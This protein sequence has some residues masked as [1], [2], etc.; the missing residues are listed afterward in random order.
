MF[1]DIIMTT[2]LVNENANSYFQNIYGDSFNGDISFISTLRA[3]VAPRMGDDDVL[4]IKFRSS[5][6]SAGAIAGA[7]TTN[8]IK[9]ICEYFYQND[10]GS[11]YIHNFYH[12]EQDSNVAC[13]ELMKSSFCKVFPGWVRLEKV[14]DFYHKQFLTMCFINPD[15]KSVAIFVDNMDIRKMHYL[16]CS[17]FA[18]L[19]WYFDPKK[20]VNEL[21][22]ELINSL[23]EK[24]SGKY[25]EVISKI[26]L[27]YDFRSSK[28]KRLLAGF[29]TKFERIECNNVRAQID[30]VR[31][32]I[33]SLNRQ[34]GDKLR[35]KSGLEIRLLGLESKISSTSEDSEIMEYFL[36]NSNLE[37]LNVY[38]ETMIFGVKTYI[39]YFDEDMAASAIRN[40]Q[41]YLYTP[42][43][44]TSRRIPEESIEKLMNA[45]FIDQ[46]LKIKI[47]AAYE[48]DL[49]GAVTAKQYHDFDNN[50]DHCMPNPHI[51][52]YGCLGNYHRAINELLE[53][54]DYI[55]AIEQCI[56][57]AKSLNFGDSPVM[58]LFSRAIHKVDCTYN[59]KCIE[60]PDGNVVDPKGAIAWLEEQEGADNE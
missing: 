27:Q 25:E 54:R 19:P 43:G 33:D 34:I 16:Q 52:G 42:G 13:L 57:S 21:E 24:T 4:S 29:E 39:E 51:D 11:I 15:K 58:G 40:K 8:A 26:A 5:N 9:T 10:E 56:A 59:N 1:K 32:S 18:F 36:C 55:T 2:P 12:S 38:D 22:M 49:N 17:I 20:G 46:T 47:C 44:D 41:S 48:F 30:R 28:I 14:T 45:I 37:L 50:F 35:T 60:L 7:S 6:Y 31:D 3:L 23:R 53:K